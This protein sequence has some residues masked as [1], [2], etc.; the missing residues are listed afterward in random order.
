MEMSIKFNMR[1]SLCVSNCDVTS[2]LLT[3]SFYCSSLC[4]FCTYVFSNGNRCYPNGECLLFRN[5][6]IQQRNKF[7]KYK[8]DGKKNLIFTSQNDRWNV[9]SNEVSLCDWLTDWLA[10]W[11]LDN[12]WCAVLICAKSNKTFET[13]KTKC[14]ANA[15][16]ICGDLWRPVKM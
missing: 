10:D 12:R 15:F 14:Q 5:F 4:S 13:R 9:N 11:W 7:T 2:I 6:S 1:Q 3:F 8:N 16:S